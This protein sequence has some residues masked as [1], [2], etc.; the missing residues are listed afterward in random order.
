M[1]C[2]SDAPSRTETAAVAGNLLAYHQQTQRVQHRVDRSNDCWTQLMEATG[3]QGV[4]ERQVT[5]LHEV[6]MVGRVRRSRY[7]KAEAINTRQATPTRTP[8]KGIRHPAPAPPG[9]GSA[10]WSR[11]PEGA[12]QAAASRVR[13]AAA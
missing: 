2:S 10:G 3:T 7:E 6:A 1:T 5:A 8:R 9:G 4:T 13:V 12:P 11:G